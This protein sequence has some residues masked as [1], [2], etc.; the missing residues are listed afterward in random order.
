MAE[1]AG[2]RVIVGYKLV[3]AAAVLLLGTALLTLGPTVAGVELR[4]L[5][6]AARHHAAPAWSIALAD[7]L[8]REA[9]GRNTVVV[10]LAALL[11]GVSSGFEGWALRRRFPWAPWLIVGSTSTLLPFE[12]TVLLRHPSL[13]RAGLLALNLLIV[14]YLVWRRLAA[15]RAAT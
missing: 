9:T 4:A 6:A 12:V 10:G 2:E 15:R 11:D 7:W 8:V 1:P 3:K 14:G 5:A 13:V